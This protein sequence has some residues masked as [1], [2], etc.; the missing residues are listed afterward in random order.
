MICF[1]VVFKHMLNIENVVQLTLLDSVNSF[2]LL[3][4][5]VIKLQITP[6]SLLSVLNLYQGPPW[7][8]GTMNFIMKQLDMPLY[9]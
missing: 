2:V 3:L 7:H 8:N 9:Q 6:Q 1:R 5:A 4:L